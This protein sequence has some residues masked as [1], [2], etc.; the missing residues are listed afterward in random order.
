LSEIIALW[1]GVFV[2]SV[3]SGFSGFAFSAA[4]GAVL[5]HVFEPQRALPLMMGCSIASQFMMLIML[6]GTVRFNPRP[7]LLAGGAVGVALAILGLNWIEPRISRWLFGVFLAGYATYLLLRRT[8]P[9]PASYP[10]R[11]Q[12]AVIGAAGGLVG[13]FTAMPG[14][15]PSI[16]CELRGCSKDE[17]RGQVQPFILGM[18]LLALI[19]LAPAQAGVPKD[20]WYQLTLSLPA[21][22]AGSWLGMQA[23]RRIHDDVV[24]KTILLILVASGMLMLR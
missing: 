18:Q 3:V 9:R 10:G 1:C 5:F 20:F 7:L 12:Q 14:A 15:I 24:R 16:W 4:A 19:L 13:V 22:F 11:V 17:Q 6:R 2:G 21:L 23:F 8:Q